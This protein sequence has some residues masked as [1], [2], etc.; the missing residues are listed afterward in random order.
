MGLN[1]MINQAL[2]Y[3]VCAQPNWICD[4]PPGGLWTFTEVYTSSFLR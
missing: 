1:I 3:Q 2:K 4:L